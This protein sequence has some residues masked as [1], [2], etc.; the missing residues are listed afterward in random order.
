MIPRILRHPAHGG[1]E[2]DCLQL[3]HPISEALYLPLRDGPASLYH[4]IVVILGNHLEEGKVAQIGQPALQLFNLLLGGGLLVHYAFGFLVVGEV[5][6]LV[7][8]SIGTAIASTLADITQRCIGCRCRWSVA[9]ATVT[10]CTAPPLPLLD[11]SQQLL[12]I[13]SFHLGQGTLDAWTG[14][15]NTTTSSR[16]GRHCRGSS[17]G[18]PFF[19]IDDKSEN[20]S[21]LVAFRQVKVRYGINKQVELP[22]GALAKGLCGMGDDPNLMRRC[23]QPCLLLRIV[24]GNFCDNVALF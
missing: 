18:F 4:V 10:S 22:P 16:G 7:A 12:Q 6:R 8:T 5:D 23:R 17:R 11:P 3:C 15:L 13:S 1:L 9:I 2:G 14:G 19:V 24:G 20:A 21:L